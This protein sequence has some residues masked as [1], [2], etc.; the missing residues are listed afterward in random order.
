MGI[1]EFVSEAF[2]E[3]Q[4]CYGHCEKESTLSFLDEND[5]PLAC[6]S[7]PSGYVSRVIAYGRQDPTERLRAFLLEKLGPDADLKGDDLRKAT[8]HPWELGLPGFEIIVAYWTQNY[9]RAKRDDPARPAL[10]VCTNCGST[11]IQ[12]FSSSET[13]GLECRP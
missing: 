3:P 12:P 7:C 11:F 8:R 6:Y 10:F 13:L 5:P 9:R 2:A 4:K 1:K